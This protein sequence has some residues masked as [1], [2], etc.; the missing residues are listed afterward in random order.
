MKKLLMTSL[1]M[2]AAT[3]AWAGCGVEKASMDEIQAMDSDDGARRYIKCDT[4]AMVYVGAG[5]TVAACHTD[6]THAKWIVYQE[7]EDEMYRRGWKGKNCQTVYNQGWKCNEWTSLR[8]LSIETKGALQCNDTD[9]VRQLLQDKQRKP[10]TEKPASSG[11][12]SCHPK[13]RIISVLQ[14]DSHGSVR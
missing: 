11:L 5:V 9:Y 12:F 6:K 14:S 3:S 10:E 13:K 7:T 1:L 8:E 4:Q 2:I